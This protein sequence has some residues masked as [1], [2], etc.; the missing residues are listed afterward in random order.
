MR[1]LCYEYPE[2]KVDKLAV[3]DLYAVA[4]YCSKKSPLITAE[5]LF[6]TR[7]P[8]LFVTILENLFTNFI[9]VGSSFVDYSDLFDFVVEPGIQDIDNKYFLPTKFKSNISAEDMEEALQRNRLM[10]TNL[11]KTTNEFNLLVVQVTLKVLEEVIKREDGKQMSKDLSQ[12]IAK[13]I[14]ELG[15]DDETLSESKES[16]QQEET[17]ILED[18]PLEKP[19][20]RANREVPGKV[21][22]EASE[23]KSQARKD[24]VSRVVEGAKRKLKEFQAEDFETD[25]LEEPTET[26]LVSSIFV[27][28]NDK[29]EMAVFIPEDAEIKL[30]TISGVEFKTL[31][32]AVPDLK[33]RTLQQL[34]AIV[35]VE[36]RV[37]PVK[38]SKPV[39]AE[40]TIVETVAKKVRA[41]EADVTDMTLEALVI[42]KA[43]LDKEIKAA[44]QAA[45]DELINA[46]RKERRQIRNRINS[47]GNSGGN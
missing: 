26:D 16:A 22:K 10:S 25:I 34:Q 9:L 35:P 32:V 40:K 2:F 21:D 4:R 47:F 24:K 33:K 38:A 27:K 3:V 23:A 13:A 36:K 18:L 20:E 29:N 28:I 14:E 7:F 37:K 41:T 1:I 44:R 15:L 43:E 11:P 19:F 17:E 8:K 39:K 45:D 5:L 6:N 31:V 42:R 12:I 46:L 30:Q